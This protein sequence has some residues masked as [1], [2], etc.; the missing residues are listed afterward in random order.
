M[1]VRAFAGAIYPQIHDLD[2]RHNGLGLLQAYILDGSVNELRVHIWDR[3]LRRPGIEKSG[4][5]HDHRFDLTS[6]VLYG[7]IEQVEIELFDDD[8][9]GEWV[10]HE[11]VHARKA[12]AEKNIADGA[13]SLLAGRYNRRTHNVVIPAGN[14]YSFPKRQFHGTNA[15]DFAITLLMKTNQEN[16]PARILAPYGEPVVHAFADP[17]KREHRADYR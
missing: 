1:T 17:L 10:L 7:T 9:N 4:L 14:A 15:S 16:T 11:V 5:L 3:S 8:E 12:M 6:Y 2:W 13:V